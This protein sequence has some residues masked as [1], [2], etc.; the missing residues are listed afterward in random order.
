[1]ELTRR[2]VASL[3]GLNPACLYRLIVRLLEASWKPL[4]SPAH[5]AEALSAG[6]NMSS[7]HLAPACITSS[8]FTSARL[9]YLFLSL[10]TSYFPAETLSER[11][12]LSSINLT[13]SCITS[14]SFASSRLS[15]LFLYVFLL[16]LFIF[17]LR[18]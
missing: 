10:F 12:N 15:H 8:S 5:R 18:C 3:P 13:L 11:E 17:L 2:G 7:I 14:S 4:G 9:S 16:S 6:E 1:M